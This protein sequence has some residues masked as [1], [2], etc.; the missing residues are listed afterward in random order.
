MKFWVVLGS[1]GCKEK[2]LLTALS[3]QLFEVVFW[4][5]CVQKEYFIL[6]FQKHLQTKSDLHISICQS[7][8]KRHILIWDTLYLSMQNKHEKASFQFCYFYTSIY[9]HATYDC[10]EKSLRPDKMAGR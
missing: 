9:E 3:K 5:F 8:F 7:Q 4:T 2:N 10:L 6:G 1:R